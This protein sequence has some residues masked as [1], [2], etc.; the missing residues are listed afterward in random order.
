MPAMALAGLVRS[1][2]T[3]LLVV[4]VVA[5]P[6]VC[7]CEHDHVPASPIVITED[8]ESSTDHSHGSC[9]GNEPNCP[10]VEPPQVKAT[11]TSSPVAADPPAVSPTVD[12]TVP[13][14]R[15]ALDPSSSDPGTGDPP[16]Y[17]TGCALRF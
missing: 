2:L 16:I 11:V 3:P 1:G 4:L 15:T 14:A 5:P 8:D 7:T 12:L 10:C 9:P 6:R 13:V 17:L